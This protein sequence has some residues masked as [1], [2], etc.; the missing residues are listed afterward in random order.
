MRITIALLNK[1]KR[2]LIMSGF[3]ENVLNSIIQDSDSEVKEFSR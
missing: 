3:F 2:F 1:D